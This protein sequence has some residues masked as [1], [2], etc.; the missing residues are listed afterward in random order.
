MDYLLKT[1]E[2]SQGIYDDTTS[3]MLNSDV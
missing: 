3:L 2:I 1:I